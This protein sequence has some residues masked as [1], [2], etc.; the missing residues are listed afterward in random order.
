MSPGEKTTDRITADDLLDAMAMAD[1]LETFLLL[2]PVDQEKFASWI[3]KARDNESHWRRI[4]ALVM[5]MTS[6][7]LQPNRPRGR[8]H[9]LDPVE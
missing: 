3:G 9:D 8:G 7:F 5:A 1:V 2:P 6:G 4:N